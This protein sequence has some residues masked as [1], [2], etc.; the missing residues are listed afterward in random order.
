ECPRRHPHKLR[1][2]LQ[3]ALGQVHEPGLVAAVRTSGLTLKPQI[4][5]VTRGFQI[6]VCRTCS[7]GDFSPLIKTSRT[8][9]S[10]PFRSYRSTTFPR[11]TISSPSHAARNFRT[12]LP[13]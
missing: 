1:G 9:N 11:T 4:H 10:W 12:S 6:A 13:T 7:M 5:R 2:T 8:T 3:V